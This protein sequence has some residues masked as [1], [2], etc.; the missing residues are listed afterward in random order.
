[1]FLLES[2]REDF[3][4]KLNQLRRITSHGPSI[5]RFIEYLLIM[6]FR[7]YLPKSISFTSGLIQGTNVGVKCSKQIDI[8][9][10]DSLN[11]PILFDMDEIKVIPA[12]AVKGLI[13]IK[14]TL[15]KKQLN[16]ILNSSTSNELIEVPSTS[17]MY[18]FSTNSL[19]SSQNAFKTIK[20]FYNKK[21]L[22]NKFFGIFYSLNWNEIIVGIT[23]QN[24]S[25]I[26]YEIIRLKIQDKNNIAVFIAMLTSNLYDNDAIQSI[27]NHISPSIYAPIESHKYFLG[28]K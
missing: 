14:A 21:P 24:D 22:I 9:C 12:K 19:I 27:N 16:D 15:T 25:S 20:E 6:L 1:M 10:Y 28:L 18:V 4:N 23:K 7:K 13:E 5:G 11:Y 17:Q 26:E 8:I 2:F 3:D